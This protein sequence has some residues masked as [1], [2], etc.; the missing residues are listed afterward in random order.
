MKGIEADFFTPKFH[1][2]AAAYGIG[3]VEKYWFGPNWGGSAVSIQQLEV[4]RD[5]DSSAT[6][7]HSRAHFYVACRCELD[8]GAV[9]LPVIW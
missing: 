4:N 1:T 7:S 5:F 3:G 6:W 8:V 9:E 2:P